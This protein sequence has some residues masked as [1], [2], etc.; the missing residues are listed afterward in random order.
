MAR[1]TFKNFAAAARSMYATRFGFTEAQGMDH[2]YDNAKQ[3]TWSDAGDTTS[4]GAIVV[5]SNNRIHTDHQVQLGARQPM[6]FYINANGGL[7]TQSF[8]IADRAMTISGVEYIHGT[9][10]TDAGAVTAQV[11]H[12]SGTQAPGAGVAI[13]TGTFNCKAANATVQTGTLLA[14][15]GNGQP[16]VGIQINA[17][18]RLSIVFTGTLTA[19]AGVV[20]SVYAYAGF[21]E[22]A[23]V[24]AINANASLASQGFFLANRDA[25][26]SS[27]QMIW[28]AAATDAGTVTID[29]THETGTTA[30]GSGSSIL[31][32]AQSAKTTA[33]TVVA[34]ALTGTASRLSLA[35]GDRL[36]V[37]F[38]GTLT[39]LAGVVVVVYFQCA[40]LTPTTT[41]YYGQNDINFN[42]LANGSQASQEFFISDRDW[43]VVDVS[44]VFGTAGSGTL[45]VQIDKTTTAA[46]SG[47]SVL[48]G[49][50]SAAGSAN[51]VVVGGLS[52]SRRNRLLS[53]GD[54]LCIVNGGTLGALAGTNVTVSLLPR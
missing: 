50:M 40:S 1:S 4:I 7:A 38:T 45:D 54:R 27:V 25:V 31:G 42:L 24:Y 43:E 15:D 48:S 32:A 37:K 17:G 14:V 10:G 19:L 35:A 30:P 8:F 18:D 21:K 47:T 12:D 33:N 9:Q 5:D 49:T 29:V 51:T 11:F 2:D 39:A 22:N 52:S 53:Q 36:S 28:S 6:T 13:T 41:G 23:A 3:L 20:V 34:P 16:N 26:I 44:S 46:G